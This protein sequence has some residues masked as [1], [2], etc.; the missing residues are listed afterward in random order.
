MGDTVV[1]KKVPT[2]FIDDTDQLTIM[3][4]REGNRGKFRNIQSYLMESEKSV[5]REHR[6]YFHK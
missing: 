1:A 2:D 3:E 6:R 5:K 4:R